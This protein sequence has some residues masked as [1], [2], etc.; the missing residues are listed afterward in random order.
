MKRAVTPPLPAGDDAAER[1]L[2]RDGSVA[3]LRPSRNEDVTALR[4]FFRDLSPESRRR[5]F[6]TLAEP[7]DALLDKLADSSDPSQ[8]LT[9][10]ALRT[11]DGESRPVAVG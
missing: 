6:F 9:L 5:R 8:A 2:L 4:R 1:V 11:V 7:T 3:T 10:L